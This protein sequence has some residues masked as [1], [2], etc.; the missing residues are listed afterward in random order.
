MLKVIQRLKKVS[1]ITIKSTFLGAHSFPL[2]YRNNQDGY[3]NLI[4]N[5]MLPEIAKQNL[6]DY[7]DVFC[8][9]NFFSVEQSKTILL[10]AQK[11]GMQSRIHTNQFTHSGGIA[12]ATEINTISVDHL[13]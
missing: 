6:A 10:A 11:L 8:E 9:R 5:E 7:C 4:V 1:P 13:E 12:L 2:E 3:V